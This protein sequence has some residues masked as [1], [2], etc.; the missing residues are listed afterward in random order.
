[1]KVWAITLKDVRLYMRDW[2][3]LALGL[4][5]PLVLTAIIGAAFGNSI[6]GGI[7]PL[8]NVNII[9]VNDDRGELGRQVA[10]RLAGPEVVE[11]LRPKTMA[12]LAAARASVQAGEATAVVYIPD[13]FTA[14]MAPSPAK[15]ATRQARVQLYT[16][17]VNAIS[18]KAVEAVLTQIIAGLNNGIIT[19]EV[20]AEQALA[21]PA[22][23]QV[24]PA[25]LKAAVEAEMQTVPGP[26]SDRIKLERV[27]T[28]APS[29]IDDPLS[30]LAL[31][32]AIFFLSFNMFGAINSMLAERQEGTL[33]R[34]TA[35]GTRMGQI[36]VGKIG[37]VFLLGVLQLT[38]LIVASRLIF[39]L[40][41]GRS[42]LGLV[43]MV[44]AI[45]AAMTSLGIFLATFGRDINQAGI[46]AGAIT[47][48][49]AVLG[50]SFFPPY[51]F[52]GWLQK[53]SYLTIN[54]WAIDGLVDLVIRNAGAA[55]VLL[56][57]AVLY[58]IAGVLL[59]SSIWRFPKNLAR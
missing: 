35:T 33:A 58:G 53:L 59:I 46:A 38:V 57:T 14:S 23:T 18:A 42:A 28:G 44:T 36:L 1:M 7:T 37:G 12:D 24:D 39:N 13:D 3:A 6:R 21:Y 41:W 48:V 32:L 49:S 2:K 17:P 34:L 29:S 55:D 54:R 40:S 19:A 5:M 16:D 31:S 27:F 50:G 8:P 15:A 9:V 45:T 20:S 43:L 22:G 52:P 10:H 25:A 26:N 11:W 4:A 56:P 51:G 30:Y 47:L